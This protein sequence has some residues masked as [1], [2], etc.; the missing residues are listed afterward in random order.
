MV[1]YSSNSDVMNVVLNWLKRCDKNV[2][3]DA[4][5]AKLSLLCGIPFCDL[6]W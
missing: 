3:L 6:G 2:S 5:Q 1:S 4:Q